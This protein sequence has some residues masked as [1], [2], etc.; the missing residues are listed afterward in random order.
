MLQSQYLKGPPKEYKGQYLG[1]SVS[2]FNAG[3]FLDHKGTHHITQKM[4][5]PIAVIKKLFYMVLAVFGVPVNLLTIVILARG[6]CGL[7]ICTARYL[8]AMAA[9]DLMAII[10]EVILRKL[11]FYYCPVCFL[12]ITPVCSAIYFLARSALDCSVWFTVTFTFDR[13]VIICCRN[14][15][16][17]YCTGK[18]AAMV[19]TITGILF[20]AKN[21]PFYFVY[22]PRKIFDNV[23]WSCSTKSSFYTEPGWLGFDW[24]DTILT[25]LLP[26]STIIMLNALTVRHI[27]VASRVRKALTGQGKRHQH[28]DPEMESRRKS[29]IL[30]FAISG[31]FILLWLNII[32]D[33]IWYRFRGTGDISYNVSAYILGDVA[34][35][36]KNLSCCSNIFIYVVTQSMFRKQIKSAVTFPFTRIIQF[37]NE[38]RN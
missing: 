7:S 31:S 23:P 19:L 12:D 5:G 38:Q 24:L 15:K 26:F 35:M 32:I 2:E 8:V 37:I 10:T 14:L 9:A 16:T 21:I 1:Y 3:R 6:K 25:P 11:R 13:F 20:C 27:L 4:H 36:L 29:V 34:L 28:R 33:F 18:T 30:L 22:E 17:N